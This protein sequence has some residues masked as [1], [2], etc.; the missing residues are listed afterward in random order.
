M[1]DWIVKGLDGGGV[2]DRAANRDY[3]IIY[4]IKRAST[5]REPTL[6]GNTG[7]CTWS[8]ALDI[9]LSYLFH[10]VKKRSGVLAKTHLKKFSPGQ[11]A[12]MGK[13]DAQVTRQKAMGDTKIMKI[14]T[15]Y[16]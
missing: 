14:A 10:V 2:G 13:R 9:C 6:V 4:H 16:A 1:G 15:G 7:R 5:N 11:W 12:Q 3:T 8:I